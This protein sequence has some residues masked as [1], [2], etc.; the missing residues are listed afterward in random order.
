MNN[1]EQRDRLPPLAR[2]A[3]KRI[4]NK[5]G[6][7]ATQRELDAIYNDHARD[8]ARTYLGRAAP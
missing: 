8:S 6:L 1:P 5:H 7:H 3:L 2:L 4:V